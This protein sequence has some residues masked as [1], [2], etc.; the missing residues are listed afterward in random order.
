VGTSPGGGF[1]VDFENGVVGGDFFK[2]DVGVPA[3]GSECR[4]LVF[5][6]VIAVAIPC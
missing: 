4:A 1:R 5:L 2:G 6:G 3:I